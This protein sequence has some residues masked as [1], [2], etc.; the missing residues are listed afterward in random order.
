MLGSNGLLV[1]LTLVALI[2]GSVAAWVWATAMLGDR[3]RFLVASRR[4]GASR[5]LR[6]VTARLT[7]FT[8]RRKL[9]SAWPADPVARHAGRFVGSNIVGSPAFTPS[10]QLAQ[11][12]L[13][14]RRSALP[15]GRTRYVITAALLATAVGGEFVRVGERFDSSRGRRGRWNTHDSG[16]PRRIRR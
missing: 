2:V 7:E 14:R 8:V 12:S 6:F 11:S 4:L 3:R 13:H 15:R 5:E 9:G 16:T 10:W 1:P